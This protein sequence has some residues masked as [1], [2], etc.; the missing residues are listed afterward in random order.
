[1]ALLVRGSLS[2]F[3]GDLQ[4]NGAGVIVGG[5]TEAAAA[6]RTNTS[7]IP[8]V[9]VIAGDLDK[10]TGGLAPNQP[11]GRVTGRTYDPWYFSTRAISDCAFSRTCS[12]ATGGLRVR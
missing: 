10:V 4:A 6:A 3:A 12:A 5:D 1:M 8:I 9:A 11:G 7:G 2:Q